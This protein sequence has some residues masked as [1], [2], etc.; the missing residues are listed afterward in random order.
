[1]AKAKI[2]WVWRVAAFAIVLSSNAIVRAQDTGAST[3]TGAPVRLGAPFRQADTPS[4]R[5]GQLE[6][7]KEKRASARRAIKPLGV[8]PPPAFAVGRPSVVINSAGD[9]VYTRQLAGNSCDADMGLSS[10][11]RPNQAY[12][13]DDVI[14]PLPPGSSSF[15][16]RA[17]NSGTT[18]G[19]QPVWPNVFA[20]TIVDGGV[21]W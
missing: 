16:F 8:P 13:Q 15:V 12:N 21:T 14:R 9:V 2:H 10:Y 3:P 7:W 11:W 18:G 6:A 20:T 17:T 5:K 4:E 19:S 1:M